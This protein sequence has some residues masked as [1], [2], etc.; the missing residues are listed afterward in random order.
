MKL[1]KKLGKMLATSFNPSFTNKELT[2]NGTIVKPHQHWRIQGYHLLAD[3]VIKIIYVGPF[4]YLYIKDYYDQFKWISFKEFK[5]LVSICK[6]TSETRRYLNRPI[7]GE[8]SRVS[9]STILHALSV[10]H[11]T[12]LRFIVMA[13][14]FV[15][16]VAMCVQLIHL[17]IP[18]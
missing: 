13:L 3:E 15:G 7:E 2:L 16:G 5:N 1:L 10:V 4:K 18:K 6:N 17:L 12:I 14:V 8:A 9:L 11:A